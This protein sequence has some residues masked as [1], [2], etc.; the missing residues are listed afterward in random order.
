M[1][2]YRGQKEA[3]YGTNYMIFPGVMVHVRKH[4]RTR[5]CAP[6][7]QTTTFPPG[8][9]G[10][11]CPPLRARGSCLAHGVPGHHAPVKRRSHIKRTTRRA[12]EFI[13]PCR[14]R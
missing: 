9:G 10:P 11:L 7:G 12:A 6:T 5:R 8:R 4:G 13:Y 3:S 14:T 1:G 2:S